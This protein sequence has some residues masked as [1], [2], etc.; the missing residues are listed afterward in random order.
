M[1]SDSIQAG[2]QIFETIGRAAFSLGA[3]QL[4]ASLGIQTVFL[5]VLVVLMLVNAA[6]LTTLYFVYPR[7]VR[8]VT[9]TLEQ[10]RSQALSHA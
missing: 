3:G 1:T 8:K 5:W 9:A 10:R 4:A 7:D 2:C 6:L